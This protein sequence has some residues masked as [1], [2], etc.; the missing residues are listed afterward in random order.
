MSGVAKHGRIA[1]ELYE[2]HRAALTRYAGAI[3]G[4][5]AVAE[6]VVQEAWLKLHHAGDPDR[7]QDPAGYFYRIVRNL[8]VDARRALAREAAR[9]AGEAGI[10]AL[11][12]AQPSPEQA[13]LARDELRFVLEALDELPERTR[14]AVRMNRLEGHKLRE[15]ADHLGLS[16]GRAHALIV[17]G[18]AHCD[19]RRRQA[20]AAALLLACTTLAVG[21]A[22]SQRL[23]SDYATG[24]G[25]G[26]TVRLPDGST[27]RLGPQS[28]LRL[29]FSAWGRRV[30]L[31]SGEAQF[32]VIHDAAR[33]FQVIARD[34]TITDIGTRFDVAAL[35]GFTSVAVSLGRV[36]V[37]AKAGE[38]AF[39]L[40]RGDGA[41][42]GA[43]GTAERESGLP[44]ELTDGPSARIAA[45]NRPVAEVIDR[46]RP[47][48]DGRILVADAEVGRPLVTG[49]FDASDPARALEAAVG[50]QGGTVLRIT[51]WLLVVFK[52]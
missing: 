20:L 23:R 16:I 11:T 35:D 27:A 37:E 33:P 44:D 49:V 29:S 43:D 9:S 14:V 1:L 48:Y 39:E 34:A 36:Q 38:P 42:I 6:D 7:I 26:E 28:A 12:D 21:P 45:R 18:I 2:T 31:L 22:L 10:P 19:R 51:P 47:W 8:A 25:H 24:A 3:S 5:P 30:E 15:V 52:G 41:R 4:S 40:A 13:A 46:I 17:E 32:D 50:P